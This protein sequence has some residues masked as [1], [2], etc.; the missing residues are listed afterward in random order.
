VTITATSVADPTK[1]DSVA[2]I[3]NNPVPTLASILPWPLGA[4]ASTVTVNGSGFV[5]GAVLVM[6]GVVLPTT[7]FS[8]TR[9]TAAVT[10]AAAPKTDTAFIVI[11]PDPGAVLSN[12]LLVPPP[13][14]TSGSSVSDGAAVRFLEQ[15]AFGA[16]AYSFWRVKGLGMPGWIDAQI[17]EPPSMYPDPSTIPLSMSPVQSRF[18]TNAVH[19]RDQL[20][21]RIALALHKM[22]VVSAVTDSEPAQMVPYLQVLSNLAFDNYRNILRKITLNPAMGVYLNMVNNL[23]ANP[24]A[25]A[26]PNENYARELMQLFTIGLSQLNPDGTTVLDSNGNPIPTFT[27]ST[28]REFAR[29][30]TGWTYPTKPGATLKGL[31]PAYYVGDMVYWEPNHDEGAKT[32]LNGAADAAGKNADQDLDFALDNIFNHPNVGPFVSSN[33]IKQ[34]VTSNPSQAYV[35]RVAA[36][37]ADNG[38]GVRGDM[39]AV[40]K[41]ILLDQEARAGDDNSQF[42]L[43]AAG[44]YG[45]LKEPVV[46]IAQTLRGLIAVVNDS[47]AMPSVANSLGENIFLPPSVFS[48][49]SPFYVVE[50]SGGLLGPEFQ[51]NNTSTTI[52][53]VNQINT[54]IYGNFG[55]G[56]TVDFSVWSYLAGSPSS[57]ADVIGFIFLDGSMPAPYRT[58]L[59]AAISGTTGTTLDKARAGLYVALTSGYYAVRK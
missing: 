22:L 53:R 41:A 52:T 18:F 28:V 45:A 30:F 39:T 21:Q 36:V 33:L 23:K 26:L 7:Y 50:G 38:L 10:L 54:L 8:S 12:L 56:S 32:L 58:Q 46:F 14:D 11:N 51:L 17:N 35:A 24:A 42:A 4:G 25:N 57:L 34:L 47:N 59:L 44:N 27:G 13:P 48:Y 19:G 40:I 2:L 16:D 9:L 31:N 1:S 37:F 55:A 49:F 6:N 29:V 15:A 5:K 3:I 43:G 20:R